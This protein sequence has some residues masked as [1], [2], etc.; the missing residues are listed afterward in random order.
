M[1]FFLP[2]EARSFQRDGI[3]V[4]PR[5]CHRIPSCRRTTG[6]SNAF[7]GGRGYLKQMEAT[8][9]ALRALPADDTLPPK[10][11]SELMGCFKRWKAGT[12]K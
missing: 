10:A 3:G 2:V 12:L 11:E 1:F 7:E 5:A 4:N 9:R 8:V 6:C